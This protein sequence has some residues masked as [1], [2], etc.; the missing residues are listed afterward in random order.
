MRSI[1]LFILA[2]QLLVF[3][4]SAVSVESGESIQNAIDNAASGDT[5]LVRS[6]IYNEQVNVDKSLIIIGESG[7]I[8]KGSFTLSADHTTID[9][10]RIMGADVGILV[11][12]N[13]NIIKN[14]IVIGNNIGIK[15]TGNNNKI[16]NNYFE[17]SQNSLDLGENQWNGEKTSGINIIG[18][19]YLGGNYWKDYSGTDSNGDGLGEN[20]YIQGSV[21]D[22]LPLVKVPSIPPIINYTLPPIVNITPPAPSAVETPVVAPKVKDI[23]PIRPPMND[24]LPPGMP[25]VDL[26]KK[27]VP[28]G[29][30]PTQTPEMITAP[31]AIP[32]SIEETRLLNELAAAKAAGNIEQIREIEGNL[33]AL[34]GQT[35]TETPDENSITA[36]AGT[37]KAGY[38]SLTESG[39]LWDINDILVTSDNSSESNPKIT[40][41]NEGRLF[42]AVNYPADNV[43]R[44]YRSNN[45]GSSWYFWAW[46]CGDCGAA[47]YESSLTVAGYGNNEFLF[48]AQQNKYDRLGVFRW[49]LTDGSWTYRQIEYNA[50]NILG[51]AITSD[52]SNYMYGGWYAYLVYN[53]YDGTKWTLKSTRSFDQGGN[54]TA[55]NVIYNYA[56][57]PDSPDIDY[58]NYNLYTAFNDYNSTT[59]SYDIFAKLSTSFAASWNPEVKLTS[60]S[61]SEF[62][63]KIAVSKGDTGNKTAIVAYSRY[64]TYSDTSLNNY[65]ARSAITLDGGITWYTNYC[66]ACSYDTELY[67]V[68]TASDNKGLFHTAYNHLTDIDYKSTSYL[69]PYNLGSGSG[70]HAI[71]SGS[72]AAAYDH[73]TITTNPKKPQK[74]E[75]AIAWSD[76]RN[77]AGKLYDIYFDAPSLPGTGGCYNYYNSE[78]ITPPESGSWYIWSNDNIECNSMTITLNGNLTVYG[79]LNLN[80]VYLKM[81]P[82][83]NGQ[84][85]IDTYSGSTFNISDLNGLQGTVTNGDVWN[86]YYT[87]R[88]NKGTKFNIKNSQIYNAGYAWNL[89]TSGNNYNNAGLWINADNVTIE[90]S[91]IAYNHFIG[92]IFYNS[93]GN[94]ISNSSIYSNDWDG[95]LGINSRD[96][97]LFNNFISY[98][99]ENGVNIA[100][101]NNSFLINGL[102][103][104]G[105]DGISVS[106]TK[107]KYLGNVIY[108]NYIDGLAVTGSLNN[109]S[110][111][112]I[113][114]SIRHGISLSGNAANI[115][116]NYLYSNG[117][118]GIYA[119]SNNCSIINNDV[120]SSS[121]GIVLSSSSG[122]TIKNNYLYSNKWRGIDLE[123]SPNN[124]IST[125]YVYYSNVEHDAAGIYLQ[126]SSG[127][128]LTENQAYYNM[129]GMTLWNSPSLKV[130]NNNVD[131]NSAGI[132][133]ENSG[134]SNVSNNTANSN[135]AGNGIQFIGSDH[136][137]IRYNDA[138]S[139]GGGIW[140]Y[141][142]DYSN[143]TDNNANYNYGGNGIG[144]SGTDHSF[145][146]YNIANYNSNGI[147]MS[148][149]TNDS[150]FNNSVLYNL[151]GLYMDGSTTNRIFNNN[152]RFNNFG[153]RM[154]YGSNYNN[155]IDNPWVDLNNNYGAYLFKSHY[156]NITRNN[157]NNTGSM[158]IHLEE[159]NYNN[160]LNNYVQNSGNYGIDL[161]NS[162][163]NN[164]TLN[165]AK[166]SHDIGIGLSSSN[167]NVI[168]NNIAEN[169][170]IG[171]SMRWS[172]S[173]N[174]KNNRA[175]LDN[176]GLYLSGSNGNSLVLNSAK[177]NVNEGIEL[178]LSSNNIITDN[179]VTGNGDYG[180]HAYSSHWNTMINNTVLSN[181]VGVYFD[182]STNNNV[183]LNR[184]ALSRLNGLALFWQSNSNNIRD[185]AVDTN[186]NIS[187]RVSSSDNNVIENNTARFSDV[188]IFADWSKNNF[189]RRNNASGNDI[190]GISLEWFSDNN[191]IMNNSANDNIVGL[192][193]MWSNNNKV[194]NNILTRNNV[195]TNLEWSSNNNVLRN[196]TMSLNNYG[197]SL[198]WSSNNNTF[199]SN[200]IESNPRFG[201]YVRD[202]DS[203]LIYN[204]YISNPINAYDNA[205]NKW[206]ITKTSGTNI[207]GGLWLGGN[208]WND[209]AGVD[210]DSD[211]L[212]DTLLPYNSGGN[213]SSGGDM[214]PLVTSGS[215]P[216]LIVSVLESPDPVGTGGTSLVTVHVTAQGSSL[217]GASV[218]VSATGG[219]LIPASGTTD[220]NGDFWT[221]YIAPGTPNIYTISAAASK[222]GYANGS[223]SD[224]ITVSSN[225]TVSIEDVLVPQASE[226]RVPIRIINS[227][228][229]ASVTVRLNYNT[230]VVMAYSDPILDKGDFT[231]FYAA[232]NSQNASGSILITTMKFAPGSTEQVPLPLAL[233]GNPVVGYVRLRAVGNGGETSR[234]NLSEIVLTDDNGDDVT[235][236]VRNG[237][238][239]IVSDPYP[240]IVT[241]PSANQSDIPDDTD[242]IPLWGE[243]A[244][245]NVTVTDASGIASVTVNLTEIGGPAAKSMTNIGGNVYSTTTNASAGTLPKVYNLTVTATDTF[246]NH[247]AS[248][249]IE[250]RV[251]KNGD[252]NGNNAVNI[253]DG[254]RL[255]N[256]VSYPGNPAYALSSIYVADVSGNGV[257]NIGDALRLAN[258]VSYPGNPAY[259]LK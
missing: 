181:G 247:N 234:L 94:R 108:G 243:T 54:W 78:W 85:S 239:T 115:T 90:S 241:N 214:R 136:S 112:Y 222:A 66:I 14:N 224:Q 64:Q 162:H 76:S 106:G 7:T 111:N 133:L 46:M 20:P 53:S 153:I 150:I 137:Y 30:V 36:N 238:F 79:K 116:N 70:L 86:A 213:I 40:H 11:G 144:L 127:N 196:N 124:Q 246:G 69:Y 145:V 248:I 194:E 72:T 169:N 199:A 32:T 251:R 39:I 24:N 255:A 160:L 63:P 151:N 216:Q 148:G 1:V 242:N 217:I 3:S 44:I 189:I 188:G 71:N 132:S 13:E 168:T 26:N 8:I 98:N 80:N 187:I 15:L 178:S 143:V 220:I 195:S 37:A 61:D 131:Y 197:I 103:Y 48:L 51:N 184:I 202:S 113:Y 118:I 18:G 77:Y 209:Y 152:A 41:D 208:Y 22:A 92:V 226:T 223:G 207:I 99:G 174:V 130:Y 47:V 156:N 155:V 33:A 34:H 254:L 4:A 117:D 23:N 73:P 193:L 172:S 123:S 179:T 31:S 119:V 97:Y 221:N 67:P 236:A 198:A 235:Y 125:N 121:R 186:G 102:Y 190:H 201:I 120:E 173:N 182:W 154:E 42:V 203:N 141:N 56:G 55:S 45:N 171:V 62:S 49:N 185:N 135:S 68:V 74:D 12:S 225:N 147:Y 166:F 52:T 28:D 87:F 219:S 167:S 157:L 38:A 9:G 2:V 59:S 212:G 170:S 91:T 176:I 252:T 109:I 122:C 110:D 183:N 206:N 215:A 101:D 50:G 27:V 96:N 250:L 138:N 256:N 93:N 253:G 104:N 191:E 231:D 6:G 5:I 211:G 200:R 164:I 82:T 161:L 17:N 105:W 89:D 175:S 249:K 232:D 233:T 149:S 58:G 95:I 25:A 165:N 237:S 128:N 159:C 19:L 107:G 158:G 240:P 129:Q 205:V 258:N 114:Y 204:N 126:Y 259:I 227:T 100:G 21:N 134:S 192:S 29:P 244:R 84:Y 35:L 88:V 142:S 43:T 139:N 218:K 229:A 10:F 180:I 257:I 230:S 81:N 163:Y 60:S 177:D 57:Y 228:G 210:V 16:F 65:D 245:L 75:A 83:Y 146:R 140:L